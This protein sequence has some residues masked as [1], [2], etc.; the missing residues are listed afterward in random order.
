M[1]R[2][3][4]ELVAS[5]RSALESQQNILAQGQAQSSIRRGGVLPADSPRFSRY[6]DND[7]LNNSYAI[8]NTSLGLLDSPLAEIEDPQARRQLVQD[9][10]NQASHA[11]EAATRNAAPSENLAFHRLMAGAASHLGGFA[12]RAF[13][14]VDASIQSGRMTPMEATLADLILRNPMQIEERTRLLKTSASFTDEALLQALQGNPADT[15][16]LSADPTQPVG[17]KIEN[18]V[19]EVGPIVALLSEHYMS[20]VSSALFAIAHGQ[21]PLLRAAIRDLENGEQAASDI[22]APGPWWVYRLTRRLIGDLRETSIRKNIPVT[23]PPAATADTEADQRD[24]KQLRKTFVA[25]LFA[26]KRS[27]IDLWPSQLHVVDRIFSGTNDLVISLPTSAGKTR[28]AELSILACLA[29]GRRAVYITPLRALSAQTERILERTFTPLGVQVSSLYGNIGTTD[30]DEDALRMSDI[31]IATPEKLDFALRS[32]PS[33]L[34]DVGVVILD[35]GHMIGPNEREVRYE[36]QVQRLLRRDD[37]DNRRIVCLS[38]VF[39]S[40]D[41]LQDFVAWMTDDDPTGLHKEK[42]RP[43]QQKFGVIQWQSDHARLEMTLSTGQPAFIPR[44]VEAQPPVVGRRRRKA[45][46]A[47][48]RELVIATAW[49]LVD[50]GQSVLIFC[51]QRRGV[52]PYAEHIV[53]L[54]QQGLIGTILAPGADLADAIAVGTEWF[55]ADHPILKC[56]ELGVAIHHG[57]LPGPFRKEIERLLHNGA[58]KVTVASPTLAQGLN[59]SASVVL[60]HGLRGGKELL[61]GAQFSNVIGR[62]GRAFVD[63]EGL[64]LYPQ[65]P[66]G[67]T[68]KDERG[69]D[70]WKRL[71]TG[72]EGKDLRSGLISVGVELIRRVMLASGTNRVESFLDYVTG[73]PDWSFPE[74]E[75]ESAKATQDARKSWQSNLLLLDTSILSIIGDDEAD[76]DQVTQLLLD[77]LR[78]SLWERQLARYQQNNSVLALRAVV[79]SRAQY[80]WN[81][82]TP[83]QRRGWYLAGVGA[84]AG[85]ALAA[86]APAIVAVTVDAEAAIAADDSNVAVDLITRIAELLF[87]IDTFT[88]ETKELAPQT[89]IKWRSVLAHWLSGRPLEELSGNRDDIVRFIESDLAYRLVWG[90]EAARVYEKAQLNLDTALL[91]GTATAAVETGTLN[92]QAAIIIRSGFDYRSA[93][94]KAVESVESTFNSSAGMRRWIRDLPIALM[95]DPA[96]PTAE[97][98]RAWLQFVT[99]TRTSRALPWEYRTYEVE[100]VQWDEELP[101]PEAPLRV[102]DLSPGVVE[103]WSTGFTY[104]GEARVEINPDRKGALYARRNPHD[105]SIKLHYRGPND[106]LLDMLHQNQ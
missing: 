62:A 66:S 88:P 72:E 23:R 38:A 60:F 37:A 20:A 91:T 31:V 33:V 69:L 84:R 105:S 78:N 41:D 102:T 13:S 63:T 97:S 46:P 56:L 42:W 93:A 73:G 17:A 3:I 5:L 77:I 58:I 94:I 14:L 64:V 32:D 65:F 95:T 22:N 26:R 18:A 70:D 104:L 52:T 16:A 87:T 51:P 74:R 89:S 68:L 96:W 53:K 30:I 71:T 4:Q 80:I 47:E 48:H 6:L 10:F 25:S 99:H 49:R 76:P 103:L 35:E 92:P 61:T 8:I 90:M 83:S 12:A 100:D 106:L 7:L 54:H 82:S 28:I 50:E 101:D 67:D 86:V 55:G 81:N 24:W 59:L 29:Q 79:T 9:G 75:R 21:G 57:T 85:S 27:E 36:A 44:Y 11:L 19:S 43:T 15:N 45:F 39:P 40:G 98:R 1:A 2:E 34:N